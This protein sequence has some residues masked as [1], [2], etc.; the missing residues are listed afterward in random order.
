M[1]Y[2][3]IHF[4]FKMFTFLSLWPKDDKFI[5]DLVC[6]YFFPLF[7]DEIQQT[8]MRVCWTGVSSDSYTNVFIQTVHC[9]FSM[10]TC[11]LLAL[12]VDAR[13][14]SSCFYVILIPVP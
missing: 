13:F 11:S 12:H 8:Q 1:Q 6:T 7:F 14:Y 2:T 4:L 3:Y 10:P 9:I 5:V